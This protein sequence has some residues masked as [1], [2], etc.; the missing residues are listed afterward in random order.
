MSSNNK[1]KAPAFQFYA[2]DF[3][4]GTADMKAEEVGGFIRLLCHQWTKGGIPDDKD[5]AEMMAGLIGSPSICY[6]LAKFEKDPVDGLLKNKRL[7]IVRQEQQ[8]FSKSRSTSGRKGAEIRWGHGKQDGK[9][10]GSAIAHPMADGMAEPMANEWQ[11]DSSPS[12]SPI[13]KNTPSISPWVVAFGVEL[14]ESLRTENCLEAVKLWLKYK[15]E[16]RE[17]YKQTGLKAA[18]TKWSRE[19]NPAT[20]PSAVDHSMAQ[21][22]KGIFAQTQ[23]SIPQIQQPTVKKELDLKDWI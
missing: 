12:P 15:S 19:F 20:F 17:G 1:R 2:D 8:E 23:Q 10:D 4:A 3:L 16:R 9:Q 18:L 6:V 5:R 11:N 21:G 13:I 7:E 22:W 14:P